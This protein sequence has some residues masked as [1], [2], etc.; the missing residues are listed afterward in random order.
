MNSTQCFEAIDSYNNAKILF[1]VISLFLIIFTAI[2]GMSIIW[3]EKFVI[4]KKKTMIR[5]LFTSLFYVIVFYCVVVQGMYL[6]RFGL[7]PLPSPV[8]F[9]FT[10][11]KK[12]TLYYAIGLVDSISLTR[13]LFIFCLKNPGVFNDDFWII[14]VNMWLIMVAF[15]IQFVRLFMPGNQLVDYYF[16]TGEDPVD[17]FGMPAVGRGY[18]EF[19]SILLNLLIFLKIWL[20][21]LRASR[22]YGPPRRESHIKNLTIFQAENENLTSFIVIWILCAFFAFIAAA[23]SFKSCADFQLYP[24]YL[25]IYYT[26]MVYGPITCFL[27]VSWYVFRLPSLKETLWNEIITRYENFSN[28]WCLNIAVLTILAVTNLAFNDESTQFCSCVHTT[29]SLAL[30]SI[31]N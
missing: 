25:I 15:L 26:Y 13:Y 22:L 17:I 31:F 5:K 1:S 30:N 27:Y 3:V 11:I 19:T 8:C 9:W 6:V 23:V 21:K 4:D 12:G 7:G 28:C 14:F 24:K 29:Y 16:C 18:Y 2:G 10:I 20:Y